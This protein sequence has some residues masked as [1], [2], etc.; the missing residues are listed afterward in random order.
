MKAYMVNTFTGGSGIS[1]H[2][3]FA[4]DARDAR[5]WRAGL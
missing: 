2:L 4:E 3:F 1:Y 5:G